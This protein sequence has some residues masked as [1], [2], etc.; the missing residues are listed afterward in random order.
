MKNKK[1]IW[2][3]VW[4]LKTIL[5]SIGVITEIEDIEDFKTKER[6]RNTGVHISWHIV[7]HNRLYSVVS[8]VISPLSLLILFTWVLC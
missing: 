1:K 5:I 3:T 8:V 2:C 6:E 4:F 7:L